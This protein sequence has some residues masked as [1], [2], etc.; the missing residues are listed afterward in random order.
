MVALP[1]STWSSSEDSDTLEVAGPL[2]SGINL[3]GGPASSSSGFIAGLTA[4]NI[5]LH[6]DNGG[7]SGGEEISGNEQSQSSHQEEADEEADEEA[8]GDRW[9]SAADD[10]FQVKYNVENQCETHELIMYAWYA[11]NK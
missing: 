10:D 8:G 4:S 3:P 2:S 5:K 9:T 1:S 6:E 7:S 11:C